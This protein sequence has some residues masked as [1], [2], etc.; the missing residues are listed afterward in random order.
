ML[1]SASSPSDER[2]NRGRVEC[3]VRHLAL[4][5]RGKTEV[6]CFK[7]ARTAHNH[8]LQH[9]RY[10]R[11]QQRQYSPMQDPNTRP[12]GLTFTW[13]GCYGLCRR[14]KSTKLA[15]SLL[16]CSC[17]CFCLYG[18]STVFHSINSLDNSPLSY[19]V[20]LVLFLPY[21]SF[22]LYISLS[23][24]PSALIYPLWLIGL[25]APTN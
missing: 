5:I 4:Q 10:P 14:Q 2:E 20:L 7:G 13:W 9:H 21:W 3:W 8:Q 22:Q 1:G 17:V 18:P 15:H 6:V 11:Q 23:K 19:S 12:R 24:S 16:F 25:K